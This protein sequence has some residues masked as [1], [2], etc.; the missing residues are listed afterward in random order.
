MITDVDQIGF[1]DAVG[2]QV[3]RK[4]QP[5]ILLD[6]HLLGTM[7]DL[8]FVA[9]NYLISSFELYRQNEVRSCDIRRAF[10]QM[11]PIIGLK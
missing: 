7:T 9:E 2:N 6:F 5:D 10:R 1:Q 4:K 11:L 8:Y 3:F